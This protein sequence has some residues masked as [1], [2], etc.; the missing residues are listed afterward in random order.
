MQTRSKIAQ[1]A[2]E[3]LLADPGFMQRTLMQ[4]N[5]EA[6][7]LHKSGDLVRTLLLWEYLGIT[8]MGRLPASH[9]VGPAQPLLD[10]VPS[11]Y[12]S[13]CGLTKKVLIHLEHTML[14]Q[15]MQLPIY[16]IL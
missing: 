9:C 16:V 12:I 4:L 10:P 3:A 14:C 8:N 15:S 7:A 5:S 11:R 13:K 2:A 6:A 1:R